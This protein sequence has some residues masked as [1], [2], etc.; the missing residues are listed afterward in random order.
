[1][2]ARQYGSQTSLL[3]PLLPCDGL[4]PCHRS[5]SSGEGPVFPVWPSKILG[6]FCSQRPLSF[7]IGGIQWLWHILW[8]NSC[9]WGLKRGAQWVTHPS[10][11]WR[12]IYLLPLFI[13]DI[14]KKKIE[15]GQEAA[16]NGPP[17]LISLSWKSPPKNICYLILSLLVDIG[18]LK[19]F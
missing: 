9:S 15:G 1:M 2:A 12:K 17:C 14:L 11:S 7:T 4:R 19:M 16:R 6:A 13:A 8:S 10:A 5:L 3:T 18:S